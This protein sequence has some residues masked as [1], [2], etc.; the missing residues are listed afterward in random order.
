MLE[1]LET[2]SLLFA[3][4]IWRHFESRLSV[5]ML[6]EGTYM[7]FVSFSESHLLQRKGDSPLECVLRICVTISIRLK[8]QDFENQWT[9]QD[10]L[11]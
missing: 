5:D 9:S 3:K 8:F 6:S 10:D 11:F 4:G 1:T 2:D 7:N